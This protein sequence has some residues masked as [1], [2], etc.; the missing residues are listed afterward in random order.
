FPSVVRYRQQLAYAY[1]WLGRVS[2]TLECERFLMKA[3]EL[4]EKLAD[5]FPT[6]AYIQGDLVRSLYM[7]G[8]IMHR[9]G[10]NQQ[11][12]ALL[13][14]ALA[15]GY[16]LVWAAPSLSSPVSFG[17]ETEVRARLAD[18]LRATGR[19]SEAEESYRRSIA[20]CEQS[21]AETA[22]IVNKPRAQTL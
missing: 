2:P 21:F 20:L 11:A 7:L 5:D 6:V 10:R 3:I 13:R 9:N 19:V 18:V 17:R 8:L 14:R 1:S 15:I 22:D 4:Q 12:E 16:R